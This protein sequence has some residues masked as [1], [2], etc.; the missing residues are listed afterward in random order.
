MEKRKKKKSWTFRLGLFMALICLVMLGI[1]GYRASGKTV[2]GQKTTKLS[3][4]DIGEFATESTHLVEVQ[5]IENSNKKLLFVNIPFTSSKYIYSYDV[6]IKA[7]YDF[8]RIQWKVDG[9]AITVT[10]PQVQVLSN[11]LDLDSFRIYHEAESMF[12]PVTL[13]TQNTALVEMKNQALADAIANGLYE[14]AE[15]NAQV[16]LKSLFAQQYDFKEYTIVFETEE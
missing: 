4:D 9:T 12:N 7:G 16:L 13:D 11:E 15:A 1:A 5:T 6:E 2:I 3:F 8:S 10:L 14:R